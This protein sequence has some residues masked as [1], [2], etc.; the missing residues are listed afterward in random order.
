VVEAEQNGLI[1][2]AHFYSI[3]HLETCITT[4]TNIIE[5]E[6]TFNTV[7]NSN[8]DI[9]L[10]RLYLVFNF[11]A[12]DIFSIFPRSHNYSSFFQ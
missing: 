8:K 9:A 2:M 1:T 11:E 4:N 7:D 6:P 3:A 10:Y 12:F 5:I